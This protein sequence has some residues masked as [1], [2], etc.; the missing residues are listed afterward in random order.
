MILADITENT[1]NKE[2]TFIRVIFDKWFHNK[3][4]EYNLILI[5]FFVST[6]WMHFFCCDVGYNYLGYGVAGQQS[7]KIEH[8]SSEIKKK[9]LINFSWDFLNVLLTLDRHT[10]NA[11]MDFLTIG[12]CQS[13]CISI[14]IF[15]KIWS[16]ENLYWGK[17]DLYG[18]FWSI[19]CPKTSQ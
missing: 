10:D 15:P 14:I 8:C 18:G 5:S 1:Q 17:I 9:I 6:I 11:Q 16:F 19:F 3:T 7:L 13:D 2:M 4:S 12:V